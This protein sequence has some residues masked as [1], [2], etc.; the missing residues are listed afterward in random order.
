[1]GWLRRSRQLAAE[2]DPVASWGERAGKLLWQFLLFIVGPSTV[3]GVVL[4]ILAYLTTFSFLYAATFGLAAFAFA[5]LG[6]SLLAIRRAK[7]PASLQDRASSIGGDELPFPLPR[8]LPPDWPSIRTLSSLSFR[9]VDL[10]A[11]DQVLN[12]TNVRD[13]TFYKC[14]I[15]GPAI[16]IP[17]D[18][19]FDGDNKFINEPRA[20]HPQSMLY[21]MIPDR[22]RIWFSGTV[23][24]RDC[25]F[26]DCT[27][28]DI[29]LMQYEPDIG[30]LR[31]HI[32]GDGDVEI[33]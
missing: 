30:R 28:V 3:S 21:P 17:R 9:L 23:A 31:D 1:M 20:E 6:L 11:P 16:L 13:K 12:Q 24:T 5:Q 8:P 2:T 26:R 14:T 4:G 10:I 32:L 18:T 25:E 19:R 15:H 27:F 7:R 29:G 33:H 22:N